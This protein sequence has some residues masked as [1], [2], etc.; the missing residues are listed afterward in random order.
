[1]GR[2]AAAAV[3][4]R[5]RDILL[6]LVAATFLGAVSLVN[7]RREMSPIVRL[8]TQSLAAIALMWAGHLTITGF[9]VPFFGVL[10]LGWSSYVFTFLFVVWMT[11]L[12]N[13]MD[14]MDG[15]AGGMAVIGFGFLGAL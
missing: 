8:F 3:E 14:G 1:A 12:Y 11:N 4:L 7:D 13:F 2:V 10:R 9:S 5:H 15:L 6:T